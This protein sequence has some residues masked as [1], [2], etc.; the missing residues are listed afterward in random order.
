MQQILLLLR[1]L[2]LPPSLL[3]LFVLGEVLGVLGVQLLLLQLQ[4]VLH[5][6]LV[7]RSR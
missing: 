5:H 7:A 6:A 2:C 1:A 3:V 4:E